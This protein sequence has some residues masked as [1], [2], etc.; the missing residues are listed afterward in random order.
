MRGIPG[1]SCRGCYQAS[2]LAGAWSSV[3]WGPRHG[4]AAPRREW[5]FDPSQLTWPPWGGLCPSAC[6]LSARPRVLGPC[7]GCCQHGQ[8]WPRRRDVGG[9]CQGLL[10]DAE[11]R[12][13]STQRAPQR[14]KPAIP[15]VTFPCVH[16][17]PQPFVISYYYD[18]CCLRVPRAGLAASSLFSRCF[19]RWPSGDRGLPSVGT[20]TGAQAAPAAVTVMSVGFTECPLPPRRLS[21]TVSSHPRTL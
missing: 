5:C 7:S 10:Q 9:P 19:S 20:E 8:G 2:D 6:G 1:G 11:G 3:G 15:R 4:T 14:G 13:V 17:L 12:G 16:H 18:H 21:V